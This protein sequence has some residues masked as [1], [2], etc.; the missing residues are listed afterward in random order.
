MVPRKVVPAIPRVAPIFQVR[1]Q[2]TDKPPPQPIAKS[3]ETSEQKPVTTDEP[4]ET[5]AG[6]TPEESAD[7]TTDPATEPAT[8]QTNEQPTSSNPNTEQ[9]LEHA[10]HPTADEVYQK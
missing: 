9:P 6:T 7:Q 3:D 2:C 10:A 4:L 5:T 8:D 1:Y